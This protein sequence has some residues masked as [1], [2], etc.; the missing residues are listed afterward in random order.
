MVYSLNTYNFDLERELAGRAR[1]PMA[2]SPSPNEGMLV[3]I[4]V[5]S[6]CFNGS[7]HLLPGLK[8][9]P[10]QSQGAQD[11]PP[12]FN[13]VKIGRILGLID[14]LPARMVDLEQQ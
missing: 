3:S 13:Q 7:G 9:S 6:C 8:A 1:W 5:G 10:L 14:E 4:P 2:P 11:L 12:G